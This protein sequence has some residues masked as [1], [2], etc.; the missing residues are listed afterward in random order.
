MQLRDKF[1]TATSTAKQIPGLRRISSQTVINHLRVAGL[2]VRRPVRCDV[3]AAHHLAERLRWCQKGIRWRCA[4]WEN[5]FSFAMNL[6]SCHSQQ[7]DVPE[8]FNVIMNV[9]LPIVFWNMM[10]SVVIVSWFGQRF[11]MIVVL[12]QWVHH[13]GSIRRPIAVFKE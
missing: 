2:Q 5:S 4:K 12:P 1:R 6:A 10:G 11:T 3:L 7:M 9:V 8:S 13:E